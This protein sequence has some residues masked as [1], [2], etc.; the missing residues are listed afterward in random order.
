MTTGKRLYN[1]SNNYRTGYL[2]FRH[3]EHQSANQSF[4]STNKWGEEL[5]GQLDWAAST[6]QKFVRRAE[7][8]NVK[9]FSRFNRHYLYNQINL[10]KTTH[11]Y[12]H[13]VVPVG[14]RLLSWLL[15]TAYIDRAGEICN[16]MLGFF[17]IRQRAASGRTRKAIAVAAK[18]IAITGYQ[19]ARA[20]DGMKV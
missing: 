10:F 20:R 6:A 19:F 11:V 3:K 7:I 18:G 9:K 2:D 15:T 12:T 16:V 5:P 13:G 1:T 17:R 4:Y 14:K 8:W